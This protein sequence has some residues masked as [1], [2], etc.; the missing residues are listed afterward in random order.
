MNSN[1]FKAAIKDMK[2]AFE[3]HLLTDIQKMIG[4]ITDCHVDKDQDIKILEAVLM[5]YMIQRLQSYHVR[6]K[7][8][9]DAL[10]PGDLK[11]VFDQ[12]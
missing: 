5:E 12:V 2:T 6:N 8:L 10:P 4:Y 7:H 1:D 11:R 9:L 3:G